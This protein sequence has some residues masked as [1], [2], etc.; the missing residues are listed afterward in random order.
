[1]EQVRISA[2]VKGTIEADGLRFKD[3]DGTGVLKPYEDWR[4]S[5]EERA[6]DLVERM[7]DEEKAGMFVINS[8]MMG[9]SV[10]PG[11]A[12]SHGGLLSEIHEEIPMRGRPT[13]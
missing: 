10:K 1:M 7:T 5:P 11:K 6:R 4:L 9:I 2:R 13:M 8:Q 12:T 3:L